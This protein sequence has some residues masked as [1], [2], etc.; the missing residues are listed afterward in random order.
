MTLVVV[1]VA[2][3]TAVTETNTMAVRVVS[4]GNRRRRS[5]HLYAI[6][7]LGIC[8]VLSALI[9]TRSLSGQKPVEKE[10]VVV[11]EFDAVSI[12][13]PATAV[14]AGTR[15]KDIKFKFVSFPRHQLPEGVI[16]D[17]SGI[18][19]AAAVSPL[20]ANLPIFNVNFS[21]TF[22]TSNP[23]IE[24]IPEGMRAMTIRVDA[25]TA[26]EGWAGSGALVDVLLIAKDR[27]SVVAEKV[28]ILSAER[29]VSPVEGG[30]A[31]SVP[32]TVTLL[33]TQ[34]QCLAI[35]TAIPLGKIAFA[36]RS[37]SDEASWRDTLYTSERLKG[38]GSV[39][40]PAKAAITGFV[41]VDGEV[42]HYALTDGKWIKTEAV[43]T[44]F[45]IGQTDEAH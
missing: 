2:T 17:V 34:E 36:L 38:K 24:K 5:Q 20:P 11:A 27:T 41:A 22:S 35:N 7:F 3:E 18:L 26:V 29:S 39:K 13:V 28:K 25:T 6:F 8:L 23:V 33:V 9:V 4:S 40:E 16:R 19:D 32:S 14:A 1:M 10:Q 37:S 31:P 12:P 42:K 30:S 44:G 15:G 43:P 21:K 45:L